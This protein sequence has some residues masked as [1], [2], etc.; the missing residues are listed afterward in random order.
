MLG[1][2]GWSGDSVDLI[3]LV[4]L[5]SSLM[6]D[7]KI[8]YGSLYLNHLGGEHLF[9]NTFYTHGYWRCLVL[10]WESCRNESGERSFKGHNGYI[11]NNSAEL[12]M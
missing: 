9:G 1:Q 10:G 4:E 7:R 11:V 12:S 6:W 8:R 2:G 3:G 5:C